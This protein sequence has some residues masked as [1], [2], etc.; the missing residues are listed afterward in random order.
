[1]FCQNSKLADCF[2]KELQIVWIFQRE[3]FLEQ[4]QWKLVETVKHKFFY[5]TSLLIKL[6]L[7]YFMEEGGRLVEEVVKAIRQY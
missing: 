1:M 4:E 5:G 3:Y 6:I 7:E 2:P